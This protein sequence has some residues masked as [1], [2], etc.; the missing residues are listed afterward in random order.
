MKHV[1]LVGRGVRHVISRTNDVSGIRNDQQTG[2][3]TICGI[4]IIHSDTMRPSPKIPKCL[5]CTIR[6]DRPH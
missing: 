5:T 2:Q 3:R 1:Q 4:A 6:K